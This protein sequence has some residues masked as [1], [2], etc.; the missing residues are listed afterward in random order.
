MADPFN[1]LTPMPRRGLIPDPKASVTQQIL[2]TNPYS[3]PGQS[4]DIPK[5]WRPFYRRL[6]QERD[7][8]ID[9]EK[10]SVA[11]S[12]ETTENPIQRGPADVATDEFAREQSEGV[13]SFDQEKLDEI[14][15]AIERIENG[16]Y[17]ICEA[18]GKRIPEER[19]R[20][21]P[22]TRFTAEAQ[23]EM[24]EKDEATTV[25]LGPLGGSDRREGESRARSR[26]RDST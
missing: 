17:G 6:V 4:P 19:L 11:S 12:R 13:E 10:E 18:T 2:G 1:E 3:P 8:L 16:T 9:A 24:E 26:H 23:K 22:W 5:K 14:D 15:A 25:S 21:I 7:R 20:A